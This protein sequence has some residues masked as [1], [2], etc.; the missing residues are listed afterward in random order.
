MMSVT[1]AM[2]SAI[3]QTIVQRRK[4]TMQ[5]EGHKAREARR[6]QNGNEFALTVA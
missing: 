2:R 1:T 5:L 3:M 4:Q 6:F